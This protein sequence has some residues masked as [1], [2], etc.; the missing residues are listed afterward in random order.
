MAF[1]GA[2]GVP[3]EIVELGPTGCRLHGPRCAELPD[4]IELRFVGRPTAVPAR[5]RER[6]TGWLSLEFIYRRSLSDD[7]A[8]L[9]N[10]RDAFTIE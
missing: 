10:N 4:E 6:G 2:R 3:G 9:Q 8:S 5:V 1:A 7:D